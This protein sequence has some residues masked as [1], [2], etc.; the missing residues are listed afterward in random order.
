MTA[1]FVLFCFAVVTTNSFC[2]RSKKEEGEGALRINQ[3]IKR[4]ILYSSKEKWW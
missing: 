4:E 1:V 2:A 3:S